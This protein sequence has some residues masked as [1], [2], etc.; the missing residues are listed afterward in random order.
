M[1]CFNMTRSVSRLPI[2]DGI[3]MRAVVLARPE[4]P[5]EKYGPE[6]GLWRRLNKHHLKK[7]KQP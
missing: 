6:S 3:A 2:T 4:N 7:E 1:G 5:S